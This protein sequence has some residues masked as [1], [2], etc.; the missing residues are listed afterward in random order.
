MKSLLCVV[1]IWTFAAAQ[2]GDAVLAPGN[3]TL[4][5]GMVNGA[6]AV[7]ETFLELKFTEEQRHQ[8]Q[9][10]VVNAWKKGD[11]KKIQD[12]LEDLKYVGKDEALRA[13]RDSNQAAF[14]E[15]LRRDPRDPANAIFLAAYNAAHPDRGEIMQA[16]GLGLLVGEWKTSSAILPSRDITGRLQG[17]RATDSLMLNIFSDGR[18]HHLWAHSHCDSGDTC[19]RQSSTTADGAIS[20]AGSKLVIEAGTGSELFKA[21]CLPKA[22]L[23]QPLQQRR[24][25]LDWS[26]RR[27]PGTGTPQLCLA[28]QPFNPQ[29]NRPA[30]QQPRAVC[31]L[32]QR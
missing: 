16:R 3:P 7:W 2:S 8:L 17:I 21:P 26:V 15:G 23:F 13:T 9:Q 18:F 4:T 5:Q 32:K 25:V 27:D 10:V 29:W 6:V 22:N 20:V 11:Q 12:F 14:V 28:S 31:Y 30:G 1:L 19:C 24:E